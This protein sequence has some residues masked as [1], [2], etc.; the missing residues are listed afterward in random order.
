MES[1][2]KPCCMDGTMGEGTSSQRW[3]GTIG[4]NML[5]TSSL[6]CA[7]A[8]FEIE[9]EF[10]FSSPVFFVKESNW[11]VNSYNIFRC[12]FTFTEGCVLAIFSL[13]VTRAIEFQSQQF[14]PSN[15]PF[16]PSQFFYFILRF[17]SEDNISWVLLPLLY[18]FSSSFI[19]VIY[20]AGLILIHFSLPFSRH[21]GSLVAW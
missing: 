21:A 8:F 7:H 14:H 4:I 16:Y 3:N 6:R 18:W 10:D 15:L 13:A 5:I 19:L 11:V 9:G 12:R 17:S 2:L 1:E 20:E